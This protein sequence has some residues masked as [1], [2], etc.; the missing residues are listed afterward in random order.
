[1]IRCLPTG[2]QTASSSNYYEDSGCT[3]KLAVYLYAACGQPEYVV[4]SVGDCGTVGY[5]L[6]QV[7]D[8][9]SVSNVYTKSGTSCTSTATIATFTYY[10]V[11]SEIPLASFVGSTLVTD[12]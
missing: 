11:G 2:A 10:R 9:V 8:A 4:E 3:Q 7:G 1:M 12:S 6:Y 5:R